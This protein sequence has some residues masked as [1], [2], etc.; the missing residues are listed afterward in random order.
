MGI[1]VGDS[2]LTATISNDRINEMLITHTPPH[3]TIWGKI[4]DFFFATGEKEALDCLF[5]LC[6]PTPDLT[7]SEIEDTFFRLKALCSSGYKER[8]CHNHIDSSSTGKLHIKDESGDDLI[9]IE[10]NG[11]VCNYNIL[12]VMFIFDN[13]IMPWFT[14]ELETNICGLSITHKKINSQ[15]LIDNIVWM[16]NDFYHVSYENDNFQLNSRVFYD[17]VIGY[18]TSVN[19]G[20]YFHLWREE[21]KETYISSILNKEIDTQVS[22]KQINL[23]RKDKDGIFER[24]HRELGVY[25]LRLN[26]KCAQSSIKHIVLTLINKNG[27]FHNFINKAATDRNIKNAI[28]T[29]M[30]N[31]IS[32]HIFENM[33]MDEMS[34]PHDWIHII[35]KSVSDSLDDEPARSV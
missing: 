15:P 13:N 32:N 16:R 7:S 31:A 5:K 2:Y 19:K 29:D 17:N 1:S 26:S 34:L 9:Y 8:F 25:N 20:D 35:R 28:T 14:Q 21:E 4:K 6:N 24:L 33:F 3:M 11:E 12:G 18:I 22:N 23:S 27:S 10:I 30:V